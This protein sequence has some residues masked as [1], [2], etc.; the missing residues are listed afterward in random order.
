MGKQPLLHNLFIKRGHIFHPVP[1][2]RYAT[3]SVTWAY[4]VDFKE[5]NGKSY[6]SKP[7]TAKASN[8][9]LPGAIFLITGRTFFQA[10]VSPHIA[11]PDKEQRTASM[12]QCDT[13]H[14]ER[15]D[16]EEDRVALSTR[17]YVCYSLGILNVQAIKSL[18]SCQDL[19]GRPLASGAAAGT[20]SH[21]HSRPVLRRCSNGGHQRSNGRHQPHTCESGMP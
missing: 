15:N 1:L 21:T 18:A 11:C 16:M 4:R 17:S 13:K 10:S 7:G 12:S 6:I 5:R 2:R 14:P 3:G 8:A 9:V 19:R 20:V